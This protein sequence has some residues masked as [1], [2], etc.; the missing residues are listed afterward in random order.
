MS[1]VDAKVAAKCPAR[2]MCKQ[3]NKMCSTGCPWWI[4]LRYQIEMSNVPKRHTKYNVDTL[5]DD[6]PMLSLLKRWSETDIQRIEEGQGLYLHGNVGVGKT[7]AA[8]AIALSYI[9]HQT[10]EDIRSGTRTK[11]YVQFANVPDLLDMIKRGFDDP[12]EAAKAARKL[13]NLRKVPLVILDDIGAERPSEWARERLLTVIGGRY[14]DELSTIFTSNLT[15]PELVEPL[16][17]RLKS[18]IEGMSVPLEFKGR[19]RRKRI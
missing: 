1:G 4:D 16:G 6:T 5:P 3:H 17:S 19:D 7:T 2:H 14:D 18:R 13:E 9:L 15:I 11:Q 10:L 8:C 12:E